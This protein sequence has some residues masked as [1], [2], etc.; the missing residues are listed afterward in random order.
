MKSQYALKLIVLSTA[1]AGSQKEHFNETHRI[2][3]F[4]NCPQ[5][6][7]WGEHLLTSHTSRHVHGTEWLNGSLHP[8]Y[9]LVASD[10]GRSCREFTLAH[11]CCCNNGL[12]KTVGQKWWMA[13]EESD[14]SF[15][16]YLI[17]IRNDSLGK[18]VWVSF[19][20]FSKYVNYKYFIS[21]DGFVFLV[22]ITFRPHFFSSGPDGK[23]LSL[24]S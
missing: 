15:F 20:F 14:T 21:R 19:F 17:I 10:P 4:Q 6:D 24:Y 9:A 7:R 22:W 8:L 5:L 11:S 1:E 3:A 23:H 2:N 13:Q 12:C 16:R 18:R